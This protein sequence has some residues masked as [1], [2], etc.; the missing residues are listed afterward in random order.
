MLWP[1]APVP[2]QLST[3]TYLRRKF[4][5]ARPCL[6]P[7]RNPARRARAPVPR[8]SQGSDR[9]RP[10][11]SLRLRDAA[12]GSPTQCA[13]DARGSAT[14]GETKP[15]TGR[16]CGCA[17]A[18]RH[19]CTRRAQEGHAEIAEPQRIAHPD[20]ARPR[21]EKQPESTPPATRRVLPMELQVG[22]RFS[23]ETGEW[24]VVAHPYMGAGGKIAYARVRRVDQ[25]ANVDVRSWSAHE[26]ISV[27]RT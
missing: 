21:P 11:A 24:E 5:L 4:P 10:R 13:G 12:N 23:D 19:S 16:C 18:R 27:K 22:D 20:M 26:R 8:V 2:S 1:R 3:A 25:P 6:R 17:D 9:Q 14:S 7:Y 15:P